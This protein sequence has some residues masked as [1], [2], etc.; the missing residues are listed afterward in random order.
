MVHGVLSSTRSCYSLTQIREKAAAAKAKRS[1]EMGALREA[2]AATAQGKADRAKD[3]SSLS[4][5]DE[6]GTQDYRPASPAGA[7]VATSSRAKTKQPASGNAGDKGR[8]ATRL[9]RLISR[10]VAGRGPMTR[11]GLRDEFTELSNTMFAEEVA[12]ELSSVR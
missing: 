2:A 1:A 9:D 12:G 7:V 3:D 11:Q 8:D 10:T 6:D 4:D 5:V